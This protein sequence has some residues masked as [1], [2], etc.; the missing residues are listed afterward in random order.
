[1]F[2][3]PA[4]G[5]VGGAY[6]HLPFLPSLALQP[7]LLYEQKGGTINGNAYK[8][9][10]LELPLL[11]DAALLGPLDILLGPAL[12]GNIENQGV[13]GVNAADVG[14]IAG[15]QLSFSPILLSGRYETGLLDVGSNGNVRNGT[16]TFLAGFSFI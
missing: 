14:L 5:F 1:M 9:D 7:E 2:S 16:F 8:L 4:T 6:L 12:D 15:V 3:F 11:L 10:Y 13:T